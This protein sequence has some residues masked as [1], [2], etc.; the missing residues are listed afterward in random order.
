MRVRLFHED[1]LYGIGWGPRNL[2][3]RRNVVTVDR[4]GSDDV[5]FL[6]MGLRSYKEGYYVTL[7]KADAQTHAMCL[8]AWYTNHPEDAQP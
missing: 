8:N 3:F 7:S 2:E 6:I 1:R 4:I 5:G